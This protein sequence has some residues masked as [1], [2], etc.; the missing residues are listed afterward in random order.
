M[1]GNAAFRW[2]PAVA[3]GLVAAPRD[4]PTDGA[5]HR[6]A[7]GPFCASANPMHPR[8]RSCPEFRRAHRLLKSVRITKSRG[9][10]YSSSAPCVRPSGMNTAGG[11][12]AAEPHPGESDAKSALRMRDGMTRPSILP[13]L[14]LRGADSMHF[15]YS[16]NAR[17]KMQKASNLAFYIKPSV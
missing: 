15:V 17:V 7:F 4:L 9:V 5:A 2:A 10:N 6:A 12:W 14:G 8:G 11:E 3:G 1:L 16:G 13:A